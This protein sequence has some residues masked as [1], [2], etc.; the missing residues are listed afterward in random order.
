MNFNHNI[1]SI[2]LFWAFLGF[3]AAAL[4]LG[5]GLDHAPIDQAAR[6]DLAD[7]H[8]SLGLSAAALLVAQ[9][10]VSVALFIYR[11][12][13]TRSGRELVGFWLRQLVFL[14]FIVAAGAAA[15]ATAYRGERMF[16]WGYALPLWD[17]AEGEPSEPLQRAHAYAAYA[18]GGAALAYAAFAIFDRLFPASPVG[19]SALEPSAPTSITALIAESLAHSFRFFGG[20]A[21]WLELLLAIISGVLLCF[22][23]V[24][25]TVS[26]GATMFG[27]AIY[28]ATGALGILVL[29][30]LLAFKYMKT[31]ARIR[32]VPA[33]Y[34]S[35]ERHM[36][37]WFV[38]LGGFLSVLGL[39][40]S[41]VGLG[42]SVAL[43]IGK[44][45]SQPPG[46]A[47]TDPT[48]IIRAL[49]IF[50]LLVNFNLLFAHFIGFGVAAWLSISSLQARHQYLLAPL[51]VK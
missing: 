40:D 10:L 15:L 18:F 21:F 51:A 33:R 2:V 7:L 43:L 4:A 13:R 34:L 49:D 41:F 37:F 17:W 42:L 26:P 8:V 11:G 31:A 24:G 20:A 35:R 47:I 9:F 50:V 44:T 27:D 39:L 23:F 46:I 3:C 45:V 36:A 30:T 25:H 32:S 19:A 6:A 12:R 5:W 16:F 28:W 22:G 29:T 48:K 1:A 38:G 14:A